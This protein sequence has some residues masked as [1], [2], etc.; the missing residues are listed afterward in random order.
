MR[1]TNSGGEET[2]EDRVVRGRREGRSGGLL[3]PSLGVL[4]FFLSGT[5]RFFEACMRA[6]LTSMQ[7]RSHQPPSLPPSLPPSPF[8]SNPTPRGR[9]ARAAPNTRVLAQG[10]A[11]PRGRRHLVRQVGVGAA[12]EQEPHDL[13]VAVPGGLHQ[14][15]GAGVLPVRA[16]VMRRRMLGAEGGGGIGWTRLDSSSEKERVGPTKEMN[17]ERPWLS[18]QGESGVQSYDLG[19]A[20]S[21]PAMP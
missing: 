4:S 8:P 21:I 3:S 12:V 10:R 9:V 7:T 20:G 11:R 16:T 6:T 18:W 2:R 19:G 1:R 14:R 5:S 13:D 15:R 17:R